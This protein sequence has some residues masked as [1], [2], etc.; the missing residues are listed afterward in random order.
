MLNLQH[1][2]TLT[3][4]AA[5]TFT[6]LTPAQ[7]ATPEETTLL[8][9]N[10]ML[11]AHS[12]NPT[13]FNVTEADT[14][15][16]ETQLNSETQIVNMFVKWNGPYS[17]FPTLTNKL[18][19]IYADNKLPLITWEAWAGIDNPLNPTF[20]PTNIINGNLDA[21]LTQ[22]STD[23][24]TYSATHGNKP[25][26][27]RL[28]HE[29][30]GDWYPWSNETP[31]NYVK[32]WNHIADLFR[33]NGSTNVKWVWEPNNFDY[34]PLMN[35]QDKG[36][37]TDRIKLYYPDDQNVDILALDVYNCTQANG[38]KTFD[39]LTRPAYNELMKLNPTKPVWITELGTCEAD[40]TTPDSLGHSKAE[41]Y[42]Q[43]LLTKN[44]PNLKALV[45]FNINN[46]RSHDW[47]I[48]TS[49]EALNSLRNTLTQASNYQPKTMETTP[50]PETP[51]LSLTYNTDNT[52]TLNWNATAETYIIKTNQTLTNITSNTN[53]TLPYQPNSI[54]SITPVSNTVTGIPA[55]ITVKTLTTLKT[56]SAGTTITLTW[57]T[58]SQ[59]VKLYRN[60]T[61]LTTITSSNKYND[62]NL[63]PNTLYTY[64]IET[65]NIISQPTPIT[66]A[67]AQPLFTSTASGSTYITVKW[68]KPA[69]THYFNLYRNGV[70]IKSLTG[71]T[72]TYTDT[73]LNSNSKYTYSIKAVNKTGAAS[74][75]SSSKTV[76]TNPATPT[77]Y[78][79][80]TPTRNL[81]TVSLQADPTLTY[82][83]YNAAGL[84]VK[85]FTGNTVS[86]TQASGTKTY[87]L[88][89]YSTLSGNKQYSSK[90]APTT[91]TV[92]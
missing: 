4:T 53:I 28:M 11:G 42:Q 5:L 19:W 47:R 73:S 10:I 35:W 89:A 43:M 61:L 8:Q 71:N 58:T 45:F 31:E 59:P 46:T 85:T 14:N 69:G 79:F 55:T 17:T 1:Y 37:T 82:I 25:V 91:I 48:N 63:T 3:L 67:P 27:I 49:P 34:S 72:T 68:G 20:S 77:G 33:A 65:D 26:Y 52:V 13:Q 7:A 15:L 90:T 44:M 38:W 2:I 87:T 12:P 6:L 51:N 84:P 81:V 21:Y 41:W 74:L 39:E 22:F 92:K 62:I 30:N 64:R 9:Q 54:I 66:T 24:N 18:D 56:V 32:A 50:A 78:S 36:H 40:A 57:L 23:L 86:F 60:N 70:F 88:Q 16:F 80:T 29:M 75:A 76:W 83:I